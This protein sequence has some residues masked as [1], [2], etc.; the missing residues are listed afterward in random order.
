MWKSPLLLLL[1]CAFDIAKH[2]KFATR[3]SKRIKLFCSHIPLDKTRK[4]WNTFC[5]RYDEK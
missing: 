1:H 2:V 3:D 4:V 5:I